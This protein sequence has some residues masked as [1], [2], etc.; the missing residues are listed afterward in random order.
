MVYFVLCLE[1]IYKT[2][3][4]SQ[5]NYE[6]LKFNMRIQTLDG[7]PNGKDHRTIINIVRVL[8]DRIKS[9]LYSTFNSN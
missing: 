1:N 2:V 9:T 5:L 4:S 7:I 3:I 8:N 6:E